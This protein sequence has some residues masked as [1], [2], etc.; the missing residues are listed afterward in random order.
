MLRIADQ[1]D[2]PVNAIIICA[3]CETGVYVVTGQGL[4]GTRL[5][6]LKR[7]Q[8]LSTEDGYHLAWCS[9]CKCELQL[10]LKILYIPPEFIDDVIR[11]RMTLGQK[12]MAFNRDLTIE[13]EGVGRL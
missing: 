8:W 7:K 5:K 4:P 6:S 12:L 2:V 3:S 1:K 10:N 11:G 9:E 13:R